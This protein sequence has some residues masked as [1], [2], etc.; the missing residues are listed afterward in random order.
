MER[1]SDEL[2]GNRM[3]DPLE[4][5]LQ[6]DHKHMQKQKELSNLLRKYWKKP[7]ESHK[8]AKENQWWREKIRQTLQ[9]NPKQFEHTGRGMW[10][11]KRSAA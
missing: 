10:Q 3:G 1:L 9:C 7:I 11:L 6:K 8:K 5:I 4:T 2:V